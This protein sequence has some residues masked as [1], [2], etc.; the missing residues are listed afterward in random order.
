MMG[1][2]RQRGLFIELLLF[3]WY[4]KKSCLLVYFDYILVY[5]YKISL[6]NS[7]FRMFNGILLTSAHGKVRKMRERERGRG[8]IH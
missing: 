8:R 2:G 5:V 3:F 6:F 7:R 4:F 1:Q